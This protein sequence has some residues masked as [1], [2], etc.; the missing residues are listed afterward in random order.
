M[1]PKQIDHSKWK[2]VDKYRRALIVNTVL[3]NENR[4]L[5]YEQIWMAVP[6]RED[7][8]FGSKTTFNVYFKALKDE[9][10]LTKQLYTPTKF[11][12][13]GGRKTCGHQD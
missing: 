4:P 5:T 2:A 10:V 6:K 11:A 7:I 1:K 13:P 8:G 12:I 9:G 3:A